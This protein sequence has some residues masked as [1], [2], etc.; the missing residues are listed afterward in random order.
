MNY[1]LMMI[2]IFLPIT[3]SSTCLREIL[4]ESMKSILRKIMMIRNNRS[5]LLNLGERLKHRNSAQTLSVL[6]LGIDFS[7]IEA[8]RAM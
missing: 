4:T 5:A 6:T 8:K 1:R 3:I 2:T 7:S